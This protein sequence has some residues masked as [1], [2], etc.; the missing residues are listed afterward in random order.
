MKLSHLTF[1]KGFKKVS[2]QPSAEDIVATLTKYLADESDTERAYVKFA[3]NDE[4]AVLVNNFGG[5]SALE[6]G[7][8]TNEFLEQIPSRLSS[9]R[10]YAGCFES[11]LNAPAFGLTLANLTATAKSTGVKVSKLLELLDTKT[12]SAWEAAAGSQTVR[13]SR[14]SQVVESQLNGIPKLVEVKSLL[15]M[16]SPSQSIDSFDRRRANSFLVDPK[17]LE[18]ASRSA[19]NAVIAAEPNLTKWDTIMGDGDCG[20]TFKTGARGIHH[21]PF[22][23][24]LF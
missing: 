11:S 2:P 15:G 16:F 8:L 14:K 24:C 7:A 13:R 23:Q 6:M 20:E 18:L 17:T 3:E 5:M 19:C 4:V 10:V 12:D 1:S 22:S 21:C 9:V